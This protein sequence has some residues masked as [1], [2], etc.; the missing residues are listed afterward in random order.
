[1]DLEETEG[2][3]VFVRSQTPVISAM[4]HVHPAFKYF[5][6]SDVICRTE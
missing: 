4:T 6:I 5:A 2:G 1:M 3:G